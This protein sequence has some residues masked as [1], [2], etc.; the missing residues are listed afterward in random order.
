MKT[1][2]SMYDTIE[3]KVSQLI[4]KLD[5]HNLAYMDKGKKVQMEDAPVKD[6]LHVYS[7]VLF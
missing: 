6:H 1:M 7:K 4:Q 2:S 3:S 5:G